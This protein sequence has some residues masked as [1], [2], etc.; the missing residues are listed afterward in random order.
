MF[1]KFTTR[2]VLAVS[3]M[4]ILQTSASAQRVRRVLFPTP[5]QFIASAEDQRIIEDASAFVGNDLQREYSMVCSSTGPERA[6]LARQR[7][8]LPPIENYTVEPT[9]VFDNM[10]YIGPTSQGAFVITTN[11]GLILIDTLNS[12]EEARDILIPSMQKAG[13]DP[14]QIK[15]IVCLLYTS[16]SPRD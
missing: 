9:Q 4:L 6:A 2:I 1:K 8:G 10:W 15:Y 5:E 12:T 16:P 14:T 3:M 7:A 13:L 11:E